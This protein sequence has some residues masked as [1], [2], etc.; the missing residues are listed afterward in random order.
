MKWIDHTHGFFFL[1]MLR[2]QIRGFK[3]NLVPD[4]IALKPTISLLLIE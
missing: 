1:A 3:S 2:T 4:D